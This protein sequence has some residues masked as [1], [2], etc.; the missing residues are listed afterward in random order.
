[1]IIIGDDWWHKNKNISA[2]DFLCSL[3]HACGLS[4]SLI[5]IGNKNKLYFGG[6][7]LIQKREQKKLILAQMGVKC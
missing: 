1:M 3:A 6:Y 5:L 7:N 2:Y 4:Y